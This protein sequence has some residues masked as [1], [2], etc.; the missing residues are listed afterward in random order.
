MVIVMNKIKFAIVTLA[1]GLVSAQAIAMD[2]AFPKDTPVRVAERTRA[3]EAIGLRPHVRDTEGKLAH[4]LM[5]FTY[6]RQSCPIMEASD[7][8]LHFWASMGDICEVD[9]AGVNFYVLPCR[10][11]RAIYDN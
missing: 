6:D 5:R 1:A 4:A 8:P 2:Q 11:L 3:C 9:E 10:A 7:H